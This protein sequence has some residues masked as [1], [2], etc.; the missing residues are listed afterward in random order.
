M[1]GTMESAGTWK[2]RVGGKDKGARRLRQELEGEVFPG[3]SQW[4]EQQSTVFSQSPLPL[5]SPTSQGLSAP[6]IAMD[7]DVGSRQE[8]KR[9]RVIYSN[10]SKQ[11]TTRTN[12]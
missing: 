2:K 9:A 1:L 7:V 6:S 5:I 12:N 10:P 3:T 11:I 8:M 4:P